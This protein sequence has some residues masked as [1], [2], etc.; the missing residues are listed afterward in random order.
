MTAQRPAWLQRP[1]N[2]HRP[3]DACTPVWAPA[4]AANLALLGREGRERE[5]GPDLPG[6]AGAFPLPARSRIADR[7]DAR[8][9]FRASVFRSS[10]TPLLGHMGGRRVV[11]ARVAPCA[12]GRT[13]L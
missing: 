12:R 7:L 4:S 9:L 10:P 5:A 13:A 3:N 2:Q 1:A 11:R 6:R 8:L